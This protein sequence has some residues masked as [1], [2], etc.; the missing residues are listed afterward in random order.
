MATATRGEPVTRLY[1]RVGEVAE[2]LAISRSLAYE[3]ASTGRLP[4]IRIGRSLRVPAARLHE[5]AA[6]LEGEQIGER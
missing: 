2:M 4:A 3:M 5:W 6:A 1:Y